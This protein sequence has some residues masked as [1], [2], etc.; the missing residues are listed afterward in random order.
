MKTFLKSITVAILAMLLA[1]A[2]SHKVSG[3]T[4][5]SILPVNTSTVN[6]QVLNAQQW[7][8]LSMQLQDHFITQ[9]SGVGSVSK[10]SREHILLLLKEMTPPDPENLTAE[11][12]KVMSKKENLHY[13]LKCEIESMQVIDRNV[14]APVHIIIVDGTNG[15]MF[16]EKTFKINK[17]V[18]GSS[19]TESILLND[20]FKPGINELIKEIKALKY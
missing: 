18:P 4:T 10:L 6:S 9:L 7:Q 3:Q 14:L 1:V 2:S 19:L 13:L 20:V 11:A 15:K 12:Y 17:P 5:M 8:T 16:W